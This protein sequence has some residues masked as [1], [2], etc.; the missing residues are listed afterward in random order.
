MASSK[1]QDAVEAETL[2]YLQRLATHAALAD[3]AV[4]SDFKTLFHVLDL[5]GLPQTAIAEK[6]LKPRPT[7]NRWSKGASLPRGKLA[8]RNLMNCLTAILDTHLQDRG[9]TPPTRPDAPA[10]QSSNSDPTPR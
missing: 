2:A 6:L 9:L 4:D 5:A 8:R 1:F 10:N 3:P 7:I